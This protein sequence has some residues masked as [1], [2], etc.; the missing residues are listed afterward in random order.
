MGLASPLLGGRLS[1][2]GLPVGFA[3][4]GP[5]ATQNGGG[6]QQA[7]KPDWALIWHQKLAKFHG[8]GANA[9]WQFRQSDVIEFLIDRPATIGE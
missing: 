7:G 1:A 6:M 8:A 5:M 4:G 9:G 3:E 2:A